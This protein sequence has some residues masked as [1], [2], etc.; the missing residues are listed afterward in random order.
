MTTLVEFMIIV[1][2]DNRP[3]MLD[4]TMYD[5]WKSRMELYIENKENGIM[6]LNSVE[7]SP[8][9][10]PTAEENGETRK[11]KDYLQMC[12][13][14]LVFNPG[15]DLIACLNKAMIFM[16]AL[17]ASCFPSTN[18]QLRTSSNPRNQATIQDGRVTQLAFLA[19]PGVPNGQAVQTIILS[20]VTFQ[21]DD[22]YAYDSDCDDN[23]TTKAVL[24]ANLSNYGSYVLSEYFEQTPIDAYPDN[25]ITSESNIIPYSQYLL[26]TQQ[27]AVQDTNSSIQQDSMILYVIEQMSEQMVNH[28]TNWDKANKK[29]HSESLT[30]KL[31][32]Y[33]ERVKTFAQRLNINLSSREKLIDSQMDDMIRDRLALKQ[34]IDSLEQNLSNQIKKKEPLLQTFTVFKNDSKEKENK[35]MGKEIDLEKKVMELA[36]ISSLQ[37]ATPLV[38]EHSFFPTYIAAY[39]KY[40]SICLDQ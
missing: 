37:T 24:M 36:N 13:A 4:K 7:N 16:S 26:E 35:Y 17:A 2:T 22:L 21:T 31:E 33:K 39:I 3:P 1:D 29:T 34:Q 11:K 9:I 12:L 19:D 23:S 28:V 15:D 30:A 20:N 14:V 40:H 25:E 10:W 5:S 27:A 6:I 8:L 38:V 18:N 32:R